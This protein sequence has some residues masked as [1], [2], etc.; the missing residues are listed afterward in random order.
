M[1][2]EGLVVSRP[3]VTLGSVEEAGFFGSMWDGMQLW[4]DSWFEDD[5][6]GP[7]PG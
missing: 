4:I 3:L 7:E 1:L 2:D 5:E 6:S